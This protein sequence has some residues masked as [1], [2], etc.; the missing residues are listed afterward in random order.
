MRGLQSQNTEFF[1]KIT[2]KFQIFYVFCYFWPKIATLSERY[3]NHHV[4]QSF[5]FRKWAYFY[6]HHAYLWICGL[7]GEDRCEKSLIF[8]TNTLFLKMLVY[9]RPEGV[10]SWYLANNFWISCILWND[11]QSSPISSQILAG[12][13]GYEFLITL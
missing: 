12:G 13:G 3:S 2:R 10:R 9:S 5:F 8:H 11:H 6:S 4:G 1:I 7:K